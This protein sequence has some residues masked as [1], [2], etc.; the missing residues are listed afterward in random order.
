MN[1]KSTWVWLVIAATLFGVIVTIEK[2]GPTVAQ[3]YQSRAG[4]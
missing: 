2:F 4:G 1:S 3:A